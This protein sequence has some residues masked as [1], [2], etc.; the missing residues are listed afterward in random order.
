M[1]GILHYLSVFNIDRLQI[2]KSRN[3]MAQYTIDQ[4]TFSG[5]FLKIQNLCERD[6]ISKT[7]KAIW[8][9]LIMY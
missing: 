7:E 6:A 5:S 2:K 4:A 3:L 8:I 9:I 1:K